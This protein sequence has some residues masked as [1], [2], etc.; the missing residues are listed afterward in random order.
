MTDQDEI[1]L[2]RFQTCLGFDPGKYNTGWAF[3][4][5]AFGLTHTGVIDGLDYVD[6]IPWLN[7]QMLLLFRTFKPDCV[8]IE[9]FH[10]QY[11]R[12]SKTNFEL[13]NLTIGLLVGICLAKQIPFKLVTASTHK[14]WLSHNFEVGKRA[15]SDRGRC[16]IKRTFDITTYAEYRHLEIEHEADAANLGKYGLERVFNE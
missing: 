2:Y 8:C 12:G 13:V 5:R 3:Y 11:G 7:K 16:R 6:F 15:I 4:T 14:K 9:R 10:S 1:D